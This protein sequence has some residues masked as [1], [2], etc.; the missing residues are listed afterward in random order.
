MQS[1]LTFLSCSKPLQVSQP[2]TTRMKYRHLEPN[3]F[4]TW[5]LLTT[6]AASTLL[7]TWHV[8]LQQLLNSLRSLCP[9]GCSSPEPLS[10]IP[11][12]WKVLALSS[13]DPFSTL[14]HSLGITISK[15]LLW[16]PSL[17]QCPSSMPPQHSR[18]IPV[19]THT[20]SCLKYC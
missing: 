3:P 4:I 15:K 18:N 9:P 20:M 19:I 11:S 7:P 5:T 1:S 8:S 2:V 6:Q 14:R 16:H 13:S 10:A 17:F 12:F